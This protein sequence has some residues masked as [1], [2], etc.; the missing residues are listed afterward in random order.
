MKIAV[1]TR[2]LIRDK[3][4]GIGWFTFETFKRIALSHPEHEFIFLFDRPFDPSF[5]FSENIRPHVISPPARHPFLWYIWFEWSVR[6]ILKKHKPD[7]FVSPDGFLCLSSK[8]PSIAVIHD[9]N[10]HHR[11]FDLPFFTSLYYRKF[12][13]CF[14]R[15]SKYIAT[16]S[17]Y[18]KKD[19]ITSY[20]V[21]P[22]KV[23]VVY[24]G[25]NELF[26]PI[27][28]EQKTQI[29]NKYSGGSPFFI[30]AGSLHP[31]KNIVNLLKAFDIFRGRTTDFKL[32]IVGEKLFL[33]KMIQKTLKNMVFKNYVIFTGRM[34]PD[35]LSE[36]MAAAEALTYI[37][38]F[39]GFGIP[40]LEA[41]HCEIPILASGLTSLPEVAE[42]AAIYAD[43]SDIVDIAEKM[44]LISTDYALRDKL[45]EA[46]K[47]RRTHFSWESTANKLWD[48]ITEASNNITYA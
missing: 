22:E 45:I 11:P 44:Q 27:T 5:I 36:I 15:K 25:V 20:G 18:S 31:R 16:V 33:T 26:N 38:F 12:F 48:L 30:Y 21:D 39:E 8:V 24:N 14:A 3:L 42:G 37:P 47:R 2:L 43:P 40:L 9:I 6:Y 41:R 10:F 17:N 4:D 19:I 7:V 35:K 34:E 32:L 46:G 13:P 29:K 23:R 1:N 28:T